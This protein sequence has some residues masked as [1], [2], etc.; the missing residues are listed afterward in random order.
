MRRKT[1]PV[2]CTKMAR[3]MHHFI[4]IQIGCQMMRQSAILETVN[5]FGSTHDVH[6]PILGRT[7][8]CFGALQAC[9]MS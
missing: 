3:D 1:V 9:T 6:A 4:G 8:T 2:E 5:P 7:Q